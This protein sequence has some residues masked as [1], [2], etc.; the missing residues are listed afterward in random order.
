MQVEAEPGATPSI[1]ETALISLTLKRGV[2]RSVV[3]V[4]PPSQSTRSQ[5]P[6]TGLKTQIGLSPPLN[7]GAK[8]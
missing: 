5:N 6:S 1:A 3:D 8:R 4:E 2:F 7:E